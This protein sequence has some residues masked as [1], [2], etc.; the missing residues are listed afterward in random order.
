[1]CKIKVGCSKTALVRH[2]QGNTHKEAT[3]RTATLEKTNKKIDSILG[4]SDKD[5]ARM[6]IKIASFIAEKNLPLSISEDLMA[7]LK[8]L[9]PNDKTLSRVSLGK[10]KT[11]NVIRQV[12]G[13]QFLRDGC[14]KLRENKFSVII[15]ETTDRSTQSQLAILGTYFDAEEYKMNIVLIDMIAIP[16]GKAITITDYL[17]KSL[18]E[19][20]IPMENVIGFCADTCNVMFGVNHSV[21]KLLKERF[22]WIQTVKCSCHSI[23]LCASHAGKKIP[24]SLED[25]CRNIYAHFNASS[26]RT[27]ALREFQEFFE[28]DKHKILQASQTRWLSMKQCVDRI[29]E[30]YD[31]LTHY[32]TGVVFEDPTHTNDMILKSLKNKFTLAYLEF[33]SFNLGRLVSFNTLYQSEMPLLHE[34]EIEIR[35]LL[36]AVYLDFLDLKYVRETDAFSI[37]L[38]KNTIPLTKT[39]IGVKASHTMR[40]IIDNLG[41]KHNDVQMFFSHCKNFLIE[42]VGQIKKRFEDCQNFKF[43]SCLSPKIAHNLSVPSFAEIYESLPYLT[44][45]ADLEDV[46]KEW[47]AHAMNPSLNDEM[48]CSEYWRVALHDKNSAG[49]KIYPNLA[50]IMSVLLSFPF[51]NAAV[52]RLFS[53]LSLIKS[54]HRASLKQESLVALLQPK[55]YFKDRGSGQAGKYEPTEEMISLHKKMI[56]NATDSTAEELRKNFLK[57]L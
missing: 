48:E 4:P 18:E 50:K 23:H 41:D 5:K 7:L 8:S 52:E 9:F 15:D 57:D 24:K 55:T 33:M 21:S 26:K 31:V 16:D 29:I 36:K 2:Q 3:T 32:F 39:Y 51:S 47:R 25:L 27:D 1:M 54:K 13:F 12:L 6:E 20:H 34:L 37:D 10:Q 30:Q 17:V 49:N 14:Q 46:D 45:V 43:L 44:E 56:S 35:K 11:T 22:P 40:E 38:D 19:R 42:L 53:Q 28:T